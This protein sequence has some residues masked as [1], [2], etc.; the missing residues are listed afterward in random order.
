M[1][2]FKTFRKI[3]FYLIGLLTLY[4]YYFNE[5]HH[6]YFDSFYLEGKTRFFS[7]TVHL[8]YLITFLFFL[9]NKRDNQSLGL[10]KDIEIPGFLIKLWKIISFFWTTAVVIFLI[11]VFFVLL[12]LIVSPTDFIHYYS[13]QNAKNIQKDSV[14]T[15][16][17]EKYD[18]THHGHGYYRL[19]LNNV[20]HHQEYT[21]RVSK[22]C[23]ENRQVGD[24]LKFV[25][26]YQKGLIYYIDFKADTIMHCP[27]RCNTSKIMKSID[28]PTH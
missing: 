22:N 25:Y 10:F 26:H 16:I 1:K 20:P 19:V 2:Y 4:I 17:K 15:V 3:Y 14:C 5:T 13:I 11:V 8:L 7:L 28:D 12:E 18:Y 24:S 9:F 23:Y 6:I 27:P 21:L